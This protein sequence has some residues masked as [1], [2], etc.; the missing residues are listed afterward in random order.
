LGARSA[1]TLNDGT[2]YAGELQKV[3]AGHFIQLGGSVTH[4]LTFRQGI[5]SFSRVLGTIAQDS[6]DL[7]Y[8]PVFM[9]DGQYII[10]QAKDTPG[11]ENTRLMGADGLYTPDLVYGAGSAVNGFMV[12][13]AVLESPQYDEFLDKYVAKFDS[14]PMNI[15]HAHAYDAFNIIKAAIEKVAVVLADGSVY[16][17]RQALRDAIATTENFPGVT[18][19]LTCN[20][21]GECANPVI[22]IYEFKGGQYPPDLIWK[23]GE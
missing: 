19:V 10:E 12:S 18:G 9:P 23:Q 15:F 8:F 6:P 11:L 14:Y 20:S 22:G 1:A 21:Y 2:L 3:F 17:P 4:Q 13:S 5:T 7:L 16:I